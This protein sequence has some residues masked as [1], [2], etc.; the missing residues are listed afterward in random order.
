[1]HAAMRA[2]NHVLVLEGRFVLPGQ[3]LA[4]RAEQQINQKHDGGQKQ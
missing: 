4:E 3:I 1:M 2:T